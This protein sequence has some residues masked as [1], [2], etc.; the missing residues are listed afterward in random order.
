M[1]LL[2][3]FLNHK[4]TRTGQRE[5]REKATQNGEK[6]VSTQGLGRH[7]KVDPNSA[8][9]KTKKPILFF[10]LENTQTAPQVTAPDNQRSE[11][12]V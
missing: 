1:L 3:L 8:V 12:R 4:P 5:K 10:L 2:L 6:W 11:G 9:K 7:D